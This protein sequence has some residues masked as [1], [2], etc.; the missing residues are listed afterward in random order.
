MTNIYTP[1]KNISFKNEQKSLSLSRN[2]HEEAPSYAKKGFTEANHRKYRLM[3][4]EQ[5]RIDES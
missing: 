2:N 5:Y 3:T 4:E 1:E